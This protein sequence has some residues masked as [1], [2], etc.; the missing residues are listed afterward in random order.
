MTSTSEPRKREQHGTAVH[1]TSGFVGFV[2]LGSPT[3][4][5]THPSEQEIPA[6]AL[7]AAA[8]PVPA[9]AHARPQISSGGTCTGHTTCP[10][11]G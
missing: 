5:H 2:A 11:C 3:P 7:Q 1:G 8:M 10:C 9:R 6:G 4:H